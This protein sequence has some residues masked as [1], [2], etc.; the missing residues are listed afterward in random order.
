MTRRKSA[1]TFHRVRPTI[2]QRTRAG[3]TGMWNHG[4][5]T[6]SGV[7]SATL[8][9]RST[10]PDT[11]PCATAELDADRPHRGLR[12]VDVRRERTAPERFDEDAV[13]RLRE[14]D[15]AVRLEDVADHGPVGGDVL[16]RA[17]RR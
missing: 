1:A 14:V 2:R 6:A 7:V 11:P 15:V 8:A 3:T 10:V 17:H 16:S 5:R 12:V 4:L 9:T 13:V